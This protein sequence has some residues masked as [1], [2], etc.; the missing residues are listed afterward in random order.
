MKNKTRIW[1]F[2]GMVLLITWS[3]PHSAPACH[4]HPDA[5]AHADSAPNRIP[6]CAH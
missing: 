3:I 5:F 6:N 1:F 4:I 2:L